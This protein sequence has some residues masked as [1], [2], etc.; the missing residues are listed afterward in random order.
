MKRRGTLWGSLTVG[1]AAFSACFVDTDIQRNACTSDSDCA[2]GLTCQATDQGMACVAACLSPDASMLPCADASVAWEPR[3]LDA[4]LFDGG[5]WAQLSAG[6][7]CSILSNNCALACHHANSVTI[8]PGDGPVP[9]SFVLDTYEDTQ[10][11]GGAVVYGAKSVAAAVVCFSSLGLMPPRSYG[12]S[13][14]ALTQEDQRTLQQ[15]ACLGAPEF[16]PGA[17]PLPDSGTANG[18]CP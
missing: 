12:M 7:V 8:V 5:Q 11:D 6:S 1:M 18:S 17:G 9:A 3:L 2:V 13:Y 16:L 10:L 14:G 4:G 15:W